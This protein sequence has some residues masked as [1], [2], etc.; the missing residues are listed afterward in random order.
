MA[1]TKSACKGTWVSGWINLASLCLITLLLSFQLWVTPASNG[2]SDFKSMSQFKLLVDKATSNCRG[3]LTKGAGWLERQSHRKQCATIKSM[4]FWRAQNAKGE[5][6]KKGK[7][8][9][10]CCAIRKKKTQRNTQE[11]CQDAFLFGNKVPG[12]ASAE[13]WWNL[14]CYSH[15]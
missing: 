4:S 1:W 11:E 9:I 15:L 2:G 6:Q 14:C 13:W 10:P 5:R 12:T 7:E 3:C 8:T